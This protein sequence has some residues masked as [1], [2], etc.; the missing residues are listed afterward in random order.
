M[1]RLELVLAEQAIDDSVR[2]FLQ[3]RRMAMRFGNPWY[4]KV[5]LFWNLSP[6]PSG[7]AK[8]TTFSP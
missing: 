8:K 6:S 1:N 7:K 2:S 3:G 4:Q 5:K